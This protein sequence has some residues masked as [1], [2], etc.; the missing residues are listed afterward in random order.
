LAL[1]CILKNV[2]RNHHKL[3]SGGV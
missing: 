2:I 3:Y 1:T